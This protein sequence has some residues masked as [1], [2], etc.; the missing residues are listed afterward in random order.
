MKWI[1][2]T[3]LTLAA[4][5]H[6]TAT[7][8]TLCTPRLISYWINANASVGIVTPV[9]QAGSFVEEG[10]AA[11]P[12][13]VTNLPSLCAVSFTVKDGNG[14]STY[15]FGLFLPDEWNHNILAVGNDGFSGGINWP[16]MGAGAKYGYVTLSTDGGHNSTANDL[17]WALNN[18]EGQLDFGHRALHNSHRLAQRVVERYYGVAFEKSYFTGTSQGGRQGLKAAQL[19]PSDYSAILIGAP[20]WWQSHLQSWRLSR[21]ALNQPA[22]D[23][24][25]ISA[26]K[27]T[28]LGDNVRK[29]CDS[30]DGVE[31]SIVSNPFSCNVDFSLFT[32]GSSGVDES[33]CLNSQQVE[34]AKKLYGTYEVDGVKAFPGLSPSSEYEWGSVLGNDTELNEEAE[35]Y[36]QNFVYNN[37]EWSWAC[38]NDSVLAYASETNAGDLDVNDFNL[39]EFQSLGGKIIMYHGMA[40]A[41]VPVNSS[42][43]FYEKVVNATGGNIETTRGWFRLFLVPGLGHHGTHVDAPWYIGGPV[44]YLEI[45]TVGSTTM[46]TPQPPPLPPLESLEDAL[47]EDEKA[48]ASHGTLKYSLLG[49]SLTKAGQDSVDQSKVSEIIYNA[50]KGSKFFNREEERDK[51]LTKK[52]EQILE[53]KHRLEKQDLSRELRLADQL[54]AQLELSRD[55]TQYI[56]HVDCDAFYAAVELLDRPELKDVPFAVGGGV[57]TTCN[58]VARKYGCRSGMAGFVAKKLCPELVLLKLNFDKYNAKAHEVREVLVEYDPRFESASIDEA[59]LNITEY[60]TEKGISPQEAVEQM[61]REIHEKTRIT[62][63]AGIAANAKL[64]K[65]CSNMNKPNGQFVLPNDRTEIMNFMAKLPPRKVNGVG[66]VLERQLTEIGIKTCADIYPH[67]QFLRQ[68]FGEKAYEFLINVYLGLGRTRIQPAEEYERK[69][70]GTESTFR[71]MSDPQQ[72]RDKLRWTAN[73]LEKDMKRAQCKGRTLV[74][75]IKLHTYEVFTRQVVLPRAI[76]LADDLYH[77]ALPILSKLEEEMPGMNLRLMGLRCTHLVSTKK[78]DTMAFFGFRPRRSESAGSPVK[79]NATGTPETASR[80]D[81]D[82]W[83][84]WPEDELL[85]FD[86]DF[87]LQSEVQEDFDV[88]ASGG[89]Q[90]PLRRHGKEIAPNPVKEDAPIEDMWDCPICNRPQAPDER[91]FNEHIDLCLSRQ[92]ILEAVHQDVPPQLPSR[93]ATPDLKKSKSGGEKKRGRPPG[94]PSSNDPRQKKLCFGG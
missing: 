48:I 12:A 21:G 73:E 19:Y 63:S 32:C 13:E 40:D 11:F 39:T 80:L 18:K 41:S 28:V 74:L 31:D 56:V 90:S 83:E 70:V 68:L 71:D 79:T 51:V 14:N 23:T 58:Y 75:K 81:Q 27:L 5:R 69:S 60:C 8:S 76:C 72:L 7:N 61:R 49:P 93:S 67:R 17:T 64:A 59:Y 55:L 77:F 52:I 26:E 50:S 36:F 47:S 42:I 78:P 92:T 53:K 24:K 94:R 87:G 84:Q 9:E 1:V 20:A 44:E 62:V 35:G 34:V 25:H 29:Q 22:N 66:R 82:G 54:I 91:Q 85:Q 46:T 4:V 16:T 38:Y 15:R 3:V 2:S 57:L 45:A 33:A 10:N 6:V 88:Q 86:N 30:S 65:I 43:D 89:E 37:P